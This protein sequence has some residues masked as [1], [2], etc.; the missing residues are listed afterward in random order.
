MKIE[1][2]ER[3]LPNGFHDALLRNVF[4]DY[5]RHEAIFEIEIWIGNIDSEIK[6]LR[7]VY[8][9]GRLRLHDLRYCAI[10]SPDPEYPYAGRRLTIDAGEIGS[11]KKVPPI[12]LPEAPSEEAFVHW[13]FVRQWNA[14]IY[15]SA[16]NARFEWIDD[17]PP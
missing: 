7:E 13:F 15:V 3:E 11:L 17:L 16:T 14:F 12:R 9:K 8:R 4:I 6:K 10:E 5:D 2:I 1:D